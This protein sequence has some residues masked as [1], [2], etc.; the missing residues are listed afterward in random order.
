MNLRKISEEIPRKNEKRIPV[1]LYLSEDVM[2]RVKKAVK[3]VF[4]GS[5]V[6]AFIN[7]VLIQ[8]LNELDNIE[9]EGGA[10]PKK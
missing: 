8:A 3:S 6:S 2:I 9:K 7:Y 10:V 1:S 4:V 5:N